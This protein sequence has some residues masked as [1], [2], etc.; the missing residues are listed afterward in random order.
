MTKEHYIE[1]IAVVSD[2]GTERI[3]LSPEDSP[4]AVFC[5]KKNAEVYEYCN[6]HGFGKPM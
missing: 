3:S 1:W 6:I 2:D 5:D 4:K